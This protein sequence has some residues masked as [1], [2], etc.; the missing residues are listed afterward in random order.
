MAAHNELGKWG[1]EQA[2]N[3]LR[4]KGYTIIEHDWKSKHRDIDIIANYNGTI[5]FV[6]VKTR[7]DRLFADPI[8]SINYSKRMNLLRTINHYIHYR[9][10]GTN[11]R[12][13]IITVVG[14]I[15]T[16]P[17]IEHYEDIRLY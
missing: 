1:E 10:L 4:E 8:L 7:R 3:F 2:I 6:E 11:I 9:H 12:F 15:G 17:E 14:T 5:I 16:I 13:D